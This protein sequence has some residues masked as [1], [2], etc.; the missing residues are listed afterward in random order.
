MKDGWYVVADPG[1]SFEVTVSPLRGTDSVVQTVATADMIMT[2][3]QVDGTFAD[4]A[5]MIFDRSTSAEERY[6]GFA[7]TVEYSADRLT[8][9]VI[10][11]RRFEFY[12]APT[13]ADEAGQAK[14][15][16]Q[17]GQIRLHMESGSLGPTYVP[18]PR[19]K[20]RG[21]E[22]ESKLGARK[23][24]TEKVHEEK[25]MKWGLSV[26]VR[27]DGEAIEKTSID[28]K[29]KIKKRKKLPKTITIYVRE[30]FW[31]E[32]RR[33]IDLNGKAYRPPVR[34]ANP[35]PAPVDVIDLNDE[36]EGEDMNVKRECNVFGPGEVIDLCSDSE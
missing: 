20:P 11:V 30:R 14:L 4:N 23:T 17:A 6:C 10:S 33:I 27:R 34:P 31:L 1:E 29:F 15:S 7:Q 9:R 24:G 3:L 8:R 19:K 13:T 2:R 12:K 36:A 5:V 35:I 22:V 26:G 25:A 28:A 32:S 16:P 21:K 18:K